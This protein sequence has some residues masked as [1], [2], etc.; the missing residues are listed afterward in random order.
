MVFLVFDASDTLRCISDCWPVARSA[1]D[2]VVAED[3]GLP[4]LEIHANAA[5]GI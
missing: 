5:Y 1:L 3:N 4:R 2:T